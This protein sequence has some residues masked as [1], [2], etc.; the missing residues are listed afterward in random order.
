MVKSKFSEKVPTFHFFCHRRNS[1]HKM[2]IFIITLILLSWFVHANRLSAWTARLYVEDKDL[3]I[4]SV[5]IGVASKA[6]KK[7]WEHQPDPNSVILI[8][9][10]PE[11]I[12]LLEDIRQEGNREYTWIIFVNPYGDRQVDP[13][14]T[15]ATLRWDL[16]SL[17]VY[18]LKDPTGFVVKLRDASASDPLSLFLREKFSSITQQ[19]LSEYDKSSPPPESLQLALINELNDLIRGPSIYDKDR[20]A[21]VTLSQ[22][23]QLLIEQNPEGEG[24]RCLNRLLLDEAYPQEIAKSPKFNPGTYEL[25]GPGG[26]LKVAVADMKT[27]ESYVVKVIQHLT[28]VFTESDNDNDDINTTIHSEDNGDGGCFIATCVLQ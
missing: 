3:G 4:I 21:H 13:S 6:H 10:N 2:L 7:I 20:F 23:A 15:T 12:P 16:S 5:M 25:L 22:D 11:L 26:T 14:R 17:S 18:D 8:L 1:L 24:L 28:L 19:H 27:T 9:Y